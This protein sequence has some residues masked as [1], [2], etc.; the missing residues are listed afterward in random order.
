MAA[1]D[2]AAGGIFR[3]FEALAAAGKCS[4]AEARLRRVGDFGAAFLVA[5]F[6]FVA[7]FALFLGVSSCS[8]SAL[9]AWIS[10]LSRLRFPRP[11]ISCLSFFEVPRGIGAGAMMR[12][13]T[14]SKGRPA[15]EGSKASFR[16][17]TEFDRDLFAPDTAIPSYRN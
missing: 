3:L 2:F 14:V 13:I 17:Q 7:T 9:V 11:S 8:D 4:F 5:A 12:S 1:L 6:V 15:C 16:E 10:S